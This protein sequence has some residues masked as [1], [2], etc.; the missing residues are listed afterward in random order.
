MK[1]DTKNQSIGALP[2]DLKVRNRMLV[3]HAMRNGVACTAA[4]IAGK[5]G[6]SRITVMKS[7]SWFMEKGYIQTEGKGQSTEN[8]GKKPELYRFSCSRILLAVTMWPG[9]LAIH[10][11]GL[12]L[13]IIASCREEV[14]RDILPAEVFALLREKVYDLLKEWGYALEDLYGVSVSMAGTVDYKAG[15]LKY[16]SMTPDWGKDIPVQK[17]LQE[18]FGTDVLIIIENAGKMTGRALLLGEDALNKRILVLFSTWGLSA[19]L[20]DKG[21]VLNGKD[22]LIGEIGHMIIDPHD[23]E[24]CG[25]GSFGCAER[26][27]SVKRLRQKVK[28]EKADFPDSPLAKLTEEEISQEVIFR[29]S[30]KGD[31]FA[32][33]L[34]EYLAETFAVVLR[35]ISLLFDPDVVVFQGDY[36]CGDQYF[37]DRLR[38]HLDRFNYYPEGGAFELEFDDRPLEEL[39]L[40][41]SLNFLQHKFFGDEK[42]YQ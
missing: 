12:N 35:N 5:T 3:L 37:I 41:G 25:C 19:C 9:I 39:D 42:L 40:I 8:G 21:H 2:A 17:Y 34:V 18:I 4:D 15:N 1:K 7:I 27:L 26:M 30:G 13:E 31:V 38:E 11:C 23:R 36:S 33:R 32:G 6:I 29:L 14:S 10:L 16:S 20:I 22:S 28:E 24:L